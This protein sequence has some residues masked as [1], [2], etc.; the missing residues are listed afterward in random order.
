MYEVG[1]VWVEAVEFLGDIFDFLP[2]KS[3]DPITVIRQPVLSFFPPFLQGTVIGPPC[4]LLTMQRES[5][6]QT[7]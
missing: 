1:I 6:S 4:S 5:V 3:L 2:P 7:K